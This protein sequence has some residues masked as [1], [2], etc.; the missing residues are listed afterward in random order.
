MPPNHKGLFIKC[1]C[2]VPNSRRGRSAGAWGDFTFMQCKI[3]KGLFSITWS[4]LPMNQLL[5]EMNGKNYF[6]RSESVS[7]VI[8]FIAN[9][10]SEF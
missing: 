6:A 3:A 2:K 1:K 8:V 9:S 10:V 5:A 4:G 7:I